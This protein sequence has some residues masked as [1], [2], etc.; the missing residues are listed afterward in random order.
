M[1]TKVATVNTVA[2]TI[3]DKELMKSEVACKRMN[4]KYS[5]KYICLLVLVLVFG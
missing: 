5:K 1:M 4:D 2:L 3:A